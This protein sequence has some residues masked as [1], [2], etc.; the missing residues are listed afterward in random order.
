MVKVILMDM[1]FEKV[2]NEIDIAI[3]TTTGAREHTTDCETGIRT[4]SRA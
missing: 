1:E 4:I 2:I 3:V